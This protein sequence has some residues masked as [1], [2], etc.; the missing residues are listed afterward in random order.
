MI[1]QFHFCLDIYPK[2]LKSLSQGNIFI[3]IFIT[4]LFTIAKAWKQEKAWNI[5]P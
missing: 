4:V 5:Q 3:P 1:Q 2:E